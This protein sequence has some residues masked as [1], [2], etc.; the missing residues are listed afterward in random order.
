MQTQYST[1]SNGNGNGNGAFARAELEAMLSQ[2]PRPLSPTER[3]ELVWLL[4][5]LR[6]NGPLY[7]V[8]FRGQQFAAPPT[9]VSRFLSWGGR[10]VCST[11]AP[12]RASR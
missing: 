9:V 1:H 4:Q 6:P 12:R 8:E 3:E 7:V 10:L 2:A 5:E 11:Y